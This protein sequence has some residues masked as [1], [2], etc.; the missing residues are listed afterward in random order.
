MFSYQKTNRYFAQIARGLEELGSGELAELGAT[1]VSPAYRGIYFQADRETLYR[2]NYH[3]RLCTRILAPLLLFDCHSTKYLYKT[4]VKMDWSQFLTTQNTFAI[5]ATTANSNIKHSQYAGLT[6]KD[7]IADHFREK[8][9]LRPSVDTNNPDIWFNLRIDRNKATISLDTSGGS[10]HRRGY[11]KETVEAPMQ[12]TVAAAMIRFSEWNGQQPLLD[13]MCGSGTILCEALMHYCNIPAAYLRT[14]FGFEMMPDFDEELWKKV[15]KDSN[16]KIRRPSKGL[17]TG[18]DKD[19]QAITAAKINCSMLPHG[20]KITLQ[21]KPYQ[22]I[23][24]VENTCIITNPPYGIRMEHHQNM[25]GF[26]E[27]YGNFLKNR[28]PESTAY[29][30]FGNPELIKDMGLKTT[31]K[32][33]LMNGGLSGI[34][35]KYR[36]GKKH[37]G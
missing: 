7:A 33:P 37:D 22:D 18:S 29:V 26:I 1:D 30:Y 14:R 32:K 2:I 31:W 3:S 12:E 17:I 24:R 20:E 19:L 36:L 21:T 13:P 25:A 16:N 6:L 5:A 4:A 10:L 15:K 23:E 34:L 35:T 28:C 8:Y 9:D 27:K 11:R